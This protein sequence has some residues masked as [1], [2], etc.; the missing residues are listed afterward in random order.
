[1]DMDW[2]AL[3]VIFLIVL[4]LFGGKRLPGLGK[5]IGQS[6]RGFKSGL[7]DSKPEKPLAPE[8]DAQP[9]L[10]EPPLVANAALPVSP[11]ETQAAQPSAADRS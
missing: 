6:I 11:R 3:L 4:V 9:P 5:S 1:M 7:K 10:R 8:S 2:P